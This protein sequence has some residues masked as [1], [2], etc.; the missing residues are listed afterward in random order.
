MNQVT[1]DPIDGEAPDAVASDAVGYDGQ[2]V[3]SV[4]V[5]S[6]DAVVPSL[7]LDPVYVILG[8]VDVQV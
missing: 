7:E 2:P 4:R 3:G 5:R 1:G 8:D 6:V